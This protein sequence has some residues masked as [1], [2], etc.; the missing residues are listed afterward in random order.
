MIHLNPDHYLQTSTGR[1]FTPERNAAAWEQLYADLDA[2]LQCRTMGEN[3]FV[4]M[5]VQGSGKSTWVRKNRARL[6]GNAIFVDAVLPGARHRLRILAVA[7]AASTPV[8]AIWINTRLETALS[9]NGM[10]PSDE[11]I[12][13]DIIKHVFSNFEPPALDEGFSEIY[14]ISEADFD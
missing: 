1:V 7:K 13:E 11:Q 8:T 12:P 14:T 3:L 9:R 10:R 2:A 5:G 6:G 4:V